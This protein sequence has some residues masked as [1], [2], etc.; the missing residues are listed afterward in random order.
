MLV[1][2]LYREAVCH[3][4]LGELKVQ[5]GTEISG[6]QIDRG[7]RTELVVPQFLFQNCAH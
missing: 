3:G 5:N 4:G 6:A 2:P 7:C 1:G